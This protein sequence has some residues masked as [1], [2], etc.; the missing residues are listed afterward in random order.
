MMW[1]GCNISPTCISSDGE[2][3]EAAIQ[4]GALKVKREAVFHIMFI[5]QSA[6][7]SGCYDKVLYDVDYFILSTT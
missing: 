5:L 4:F 1:S 3:T 7:N 6:Q 2:F